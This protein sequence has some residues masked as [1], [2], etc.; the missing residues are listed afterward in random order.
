M[1]YEGKHIG[2]VETSFSTFA[3]SV[4]FSKRLNVMSNF[5]TLKK[6]AE[7]KNFHVE[8]DNYMQS[9]FKEFYIEAKPTAYMAN[10]F[11]K[12]TKITISS[13]TK[14]LINSLDKQKDSFSTYDTSLG[15]IMTFIK[16]HRLKVLSFIAGGIHVSYIFSNDLLAFIRIFKLTA[17]C[18][19]NITGIS[20]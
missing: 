14:E 18:F 2:S 11:H 17:Y 19:K 3:M 20:R 10:K 1:F 15:E 4:E 9:P 13:N 7:K 6:N 5:L 8:T 16:V 12:K